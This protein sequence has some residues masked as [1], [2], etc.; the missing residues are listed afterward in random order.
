MVKST[1]INDI[2]ELLLDGDNESILAKEQL[3][4]ITEENFEYTDGGLFVSFSYSNE[5]TK[6]KINKQN[7]VLNG[8]KI[9]T[10]EFPIEAEAILF[11]SN[12]VIDYLEI[13]CYQGDY[14]NQDLS[15]YTLTQVWNNSTNKT[16]SKK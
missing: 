9:Q 3:A 13:W 7:M 5:I 15:K 2:L 11:F 12:G 8:V 4:F 10:T 16:I 14:P 1:F 6:Y